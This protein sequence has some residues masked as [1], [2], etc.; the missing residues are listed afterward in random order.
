[1]FFK[2][3]PTTVNATSP[4]LTPRSST[5]KG[6]VS[7]GNASKA[8][9]NNNPQNSVQDLYQ[10]FYHSLKE[11]QTAENIQTLQR[12]LVDKDTHWVKDLFEKQP[13]TLV[14]IL[15]IL[16]KPESEFKKDDSA[17][18]VISVS[19]SVTATK[20]GQQQQQPVKTEPLSIHLCVLNLLKTIISYKD[21]IDFVIKNP[22]T[23]PSLVFPMSS[24]NSKLKTHVFQLLAAISQF[25]EDGF[26]LVVDFCNQFKEFTKEISRLETF[27]SFL[28]Q[29][30]NTKERIQLAKSCVV[31][32]TSLI[33]GK[34]KKTT[35]IFKQELQ[36]LKLV[37]HI[38]DIKKKC[39]DNALIMMLADFEDVIGFMDDEKEDDGAMDD[40]K[41][42]EIDSNPVELIKLIHLHL[43]GTDGFR[44]FMS[45]LQS[46][47]ILCSKSSQEEKVENMKVLQNI[48]KKSINVSKK[49]NKTVTDISAKELQLT[50]RL[51]SQKQAIETL[52][53]N[54]KKIGQMVAT[55]KIDQ[56][57]LSRFIA[58]GKGG[59]LG[60]SSGF[61]KQRSGTIAGS[62]AAS[63]AVKNVGKAA[64]DGSDI[65]AKNLKQEI[66]FLNYQ[67]KK[68]E[69]QGVKLLQAASTNTNSSVNNAESENKVEEIKEASTKPE[70][71][72]KK[73]EDN[74]PSTIGAGDLPPPPPSLL[75]TG[76]MPPPPPPMGG[77]MPPPPPGMMGAM[78]QGPRLP[79]LPK[80]K[81][82]VPMKGIFWNALPAKSL[83]NSIWMKNDIVTKLEQVDFDTDELEN[84][85][86]A[87]KKDE[88]DSG[89]KKE[90]KAIAQKITFVEPK[91]AQN[92]AIVVSAMRMKH[93]DIRNAIMNLDDELLTQDQIKALKEIA[94]TAD[95][96]AQIE[97][98]CK[99]GGDPNL[100]GNIEK[101]YHC[102]ANLPKYERRLECWMFKNSFPILYS[103]VQPDIDIVARAINELLESE[104]LRKF[105]QIVLAIGNFL[106]SG[107]K[108]IYGFTISSLLKLRDLKANGVKAN[109][110]MYIIEYCQQKYPKVLEFKKD[111]QSILGATRVNLTQCKTDILE[112]KKGLSMLEVEVE[113][114]NLDDMDLFRPVMGDFIFDANEK[115]DFLEDSLHHVEQDQKK[116]CAFFGEDENRFQLDQFLVDFN[117]FMVNVDE[118]IVDNENRK[119]Q[120]A[121]QVEK[122]Q[123]KQAQMAKDA[124]AA[125]ASQANN[126]KADA[127]NDEDDDDDDEEL[128]AV[129]EE[130]KKDNIIDDLEDQMMEGNFKKNKNRKKKA[131]NIDTL[132][133]NTL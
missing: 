107:R 45:I 109:L 99:S 96:L 79:E 108:G 13:D 103:A 62:T 21:G 111:L 49:S 40:F 84:L 2:K 119:K 4:S 63:A 121:K 124:K 41:K 3:K 102:I 64:D 24:E 54:M 34:N 127:G 52:E 17:Y 114:S 129:E 15:K 16:T 115:F 14:T 122:E 105:L 83:S 73:P 65:I 31:F 76:D 39:N 88:E 116:L 10:F 42:M 130:V 43:S 77:A 35:K 128:V 117:Q 132:A 51:L 58:S 19:P 112:M 125:A 89:I 66:V 110:L 47:L 20:K 97:D 37:E 11:N 72:A 81:A 90:T 55:G 106:N 95:E 8:K 118:A 26:W 6:V 123:R 59:G 5:N 27:V 70:E 86:A 87:K 68:L 29:E 133:D 61:N 32:L 75:G 18:P 48:I 22:K 69:S 36:E 46:F 101:F 33:S 30:L 9:E 113:A 94:P 82:K 60:G 100:L 57:M 120:E 23:V 44:Y 50:D 98:Y 56:D 38:P 131:I 25:S 80:V 12:S 104:R 78:N 92:G 85:F 28:T 74:I 126:K 53:G 71:K 91:K 7:P 67:I 93:E 1:M